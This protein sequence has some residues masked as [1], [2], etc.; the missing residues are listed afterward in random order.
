MIIL[1]CT[2]CTS[3]I[4][5]TNRTTNGHRFVF[6]STEVVGTERRYIPDEPGIIPYNPFGVPI[7]SHLDNPQDHSPSR[8]PSPAHSHISDYLPTP[9][10]EYANPTIVSSTSFDA[11]PFPHG[12]N[13]SSPEN[14]PSSYAPG[15]YPPYFVPHPH[16]HSQPVSIHSHYP[17]HLINRPIPTAFSRSTPPP[18]IHTSFPLSVPLE[19][20]DLPPHKLQ[21][22]DTLYWHHLAKF[23]EIPGVEE[24]QRARGDI[25]PTAAG[26]K[27]AA[28]LN[29]DR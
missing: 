6:H 8:S 1:P 29:F 24:D 18:L 14:H 16:S 27:L 21:A 20:K 2:R 25:K 26:G 3:S 12:Y 5:A 9:P 13:Y 22:G 17:T 28:T 19:Q 10:L 23:G 11:F 7:T 4:T 15:P